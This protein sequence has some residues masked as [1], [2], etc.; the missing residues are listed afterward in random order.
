MHSAYFYEPYASVCVRELTLIIT[1]HIFDPTNYYCTFRQQA[2]R[3]SRPTAYVIQ[4]HRL[5]K[6][7]KHRYINT[8][9]IGQICNAFA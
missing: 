7:P 2:H 9:Q 4:D 5:V 6:P 1:K 3:E 8:I